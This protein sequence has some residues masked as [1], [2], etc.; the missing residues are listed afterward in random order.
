[1][2][3]IKQ[4]LEDLSQIGANCRTQDRD[5]TQATCDVAADLIRQYIGSFL[6]TSILL[7]M[8][9]TALNLA[10]DEIEKRDRVIRR[11]QAALGDQTGKAKRYK[12]QAKELRQRLEAERQGRDKE[13]RERI[14]KA[15]LK[16]GRREAYE[17]QVDRKGEPL[18]TAREIMDR[19]A[20][21]RKVNYDGS[22]VIDHGVDGSVAQTWAVRN[23]TLNAAGDGHVGD[24]PVVGPR[25]RQDGTDGSCGG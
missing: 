3:D 23:V 19:T 21:Q 16:Q 7:E 12:R 15:G 13:V 22:R 4:L 10:L 17:E 14:M 1:M 2:I 20:S 9:A 5:V 18:P 8:R 25:L 11:Q 24:P 6:Q